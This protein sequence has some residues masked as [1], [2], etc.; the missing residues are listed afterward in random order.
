MTPK[1][2]EL[3]A[4]ITDLGSMSMDPLKWVKYSFRWGQGELEGKEGPDEWQVEQL[5]R[6][7]E[8][9]RENNKSPS[10]IIQEAVAS[11]HGIGKSC[12]VS[13]IILWALH[14]FEDTKIVVTAN[15]ENQLKTKTWSEL[16]K[17]NRLCWYSQWFFEYT[18]TALYSLDK[19][20]EK[21]WRA[22]MIPWSIHNTEA[23]AGLH[24]EGKRIVVIFDEASSIPK[25]IWEVTEGALTDN[26]TQILWFVFGNPTQATGSFR[27]CFGSK[28]HRWN[29]TKVDSREVKITNKEKIQ[30]WIDDY[31]EDSDFVKIRVKGDFP[32]SAW[33]QFISEQDVKDSINYTVTKEQYSQFPLILGID[34]ARFGSNQN[35]ICPRQGRKVF[36]L[37]KWRCSRGRNDTMDSAGKIVEVIHKLNPQAVFM[38]GDGV[39]GPIA[40]RVKQIIGKRNGKDIVIDI[41]SGRKA[42]NET[43]YFNKRSEMWGDMR[44]A[45]GANL[46]LPNDDELKGDLVAPEYGYDNKNRIQLETKEHMESDTRGLKS[47]D[48]G[49]SLAYTYAEKVILEPETIEDDDGYEQ[50]HNENSWQGT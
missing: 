18:A 17:W 26:Y 45:L 28:R 31:G 46:D 41:N 49:D 14:T 24:N 36:K 40:D 42:N 6:I 44:E 47:P 35:S 32:S 15:T 8:E 43:K 2:D 33:N 3:K 10:Q 12:Q 48:C 29:N 1:P 38:D 11:G 21:T 5:T 19:E 50:T 13:W 20:H 9:L 37:I 7:G 34:L 25:A 16:A 39:G 22:D 23:F 27:E 30:Q 4:I